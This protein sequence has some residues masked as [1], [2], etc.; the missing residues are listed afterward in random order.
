MLISCH[1]K[2][3][4]KMILESLSRDSQEKKQSFQTNNRL[5]MHRF[6]HAIIDVKMVEVV[7]WDDDNCEKNETLREDQFQFLVAFKKH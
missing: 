5:N 1:K 4:K 6:P 7:D 2:T 3:N